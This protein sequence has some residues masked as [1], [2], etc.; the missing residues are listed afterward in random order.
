MLVL[1]AYCSNTEFLPGY[2]YED[3]LLSGV[4]PTVALAKLD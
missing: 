1:P 3:S 2:A 4:A